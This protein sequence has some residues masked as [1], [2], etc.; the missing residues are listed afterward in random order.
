[1]NKPTIK[2]KH[3]V[4]VLLSTIMFAAVIIFIVKVSSGL[5]TG[6]KSRVQTQSPFETVT[7]D[8]HLW[9]KSSSQYFVHHPDCECFNEQTDD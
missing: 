8:G 6:I 4:G 1:M 5:A 9:V 7:H 2:S 3:I